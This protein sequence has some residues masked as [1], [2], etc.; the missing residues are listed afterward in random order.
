M[1]CRDVPGVE[2]FGSGA[3]TA[4][5]CVLQNEFLSLEVAPMGAEM[6]SLRTS[7]WDDFLWNGDATFWSGRAPV[8]FP[9]V[10]RAV[11]DVRVQKVQ[12]QVAD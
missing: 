6:Q 11:D 8:L 2:R 5:C 10:G 4:P 7:A 1:A 12:R 3:M 9:I